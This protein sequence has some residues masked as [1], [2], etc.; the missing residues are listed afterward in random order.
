VTLT[1]IVMASLLALGACSGKKVKPNAGQNGQ[2]VG[3]TTSSAGAQSAGIQPAAETAEAAT[4]S[5]LPSLAK[6]MG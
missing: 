4:P 3:S 1:V 5:S 2:V 6:R